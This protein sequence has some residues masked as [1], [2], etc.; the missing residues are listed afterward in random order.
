MIHLDHE[1]YTKPRPG[2]A[3]KLYTG[4]AYLIRY[5]QWERLLIGSGASTNLLFPALCVAVLL[6]AL[7]GGASTLSD[8]GGCYELLTQ[9]PTPHPP[10]HLT[11]YPHTTAYLPYCIPTLHPTEQTVG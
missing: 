9:P 4:H 5:T 6:G 1:A 11:A 8:L 7:L 10:P 3:R 2:V